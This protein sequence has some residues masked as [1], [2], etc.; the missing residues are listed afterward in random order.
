MCLVLKHK[1]RIVRKAWRSYRVTGNWNLEIN[2]W[3]LPRYSRY[4][5]IIDC[6]YAILTVGNIIAQ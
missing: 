3:R 4:F 2:G 6:K 1:M 5:V